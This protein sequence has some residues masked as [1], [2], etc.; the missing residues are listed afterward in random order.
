MLCHE[1]QRR[2]STI[3]SH[4]GAHHIAD[5]KGWRL[6]GKK[7]VNGCEDTFSDAVRLLS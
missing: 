2:H 1:E 6:P 4:I 7:E 3:F 5:F